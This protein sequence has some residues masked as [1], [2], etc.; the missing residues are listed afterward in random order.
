MNI[1]SYKAKIA[2][3]ILDLKIKK[4]RINYSKNSEENFDMKGDMSL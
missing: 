3:N 4:E 1:C 2:R